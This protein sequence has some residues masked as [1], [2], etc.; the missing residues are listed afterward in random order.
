[1]A[2]VPT[3]DVQ[4]PLRDGG[5]LRA[6]LALP[7]AAGPRPSVIVLHEAF[8]LNDDMRRI[9]GRIAAAGYVA[10]AP[11]LF[12][13]PGGPRC[14]SRVLADGFLR[15]A[16]TTTTAHIEAARAYAEGLDQADSERTAIIGFCMGGGFALAFAVGRNL[17]AAAVN[18]G[19]VRAKGKQDL[20]GVCPVVASYGSLDRVMRNEP[21]KL[22]RYLTEL[23][24]PHD[25]KTYEGVG[26]SFLSYDN[27]PG[28]M[29][30]IPSPMQVGYDETAAEDAWRRIFA[31]FMEHLG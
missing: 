14:L 8:G 12:S 22:E 29:Q 7:D 26:H 3:T 5:T 2:R 31:F 18:Y 20:E 11:D 15:G 27:V 28:W 10:V 21:A 30:R 19:P 9:T 6:A 17:R 16:G 25:V 13:A 1:M 23:G 4:V 24:V